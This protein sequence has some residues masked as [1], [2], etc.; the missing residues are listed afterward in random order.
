MNP[1]RIAYLLE[2]TGLAGGIRVAVAQA[3][4]LTAHGHDPSPLERY[5]LQRRPR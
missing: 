5:F 2:D 1:L 3:D 4:A